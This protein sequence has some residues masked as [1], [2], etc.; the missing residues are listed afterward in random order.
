MVDQVGSTLHSQQP[1][2]ESEA[3]KEIQIYLLFDA[4]VLQ[5]FF[6][7][8]DADGLAH[9]G[10]DRLLDDLGHVFAHLSRL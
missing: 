10:H 6:A 5:H 8:L 2:V 4:N 9:L 1:I 7:L 3:S